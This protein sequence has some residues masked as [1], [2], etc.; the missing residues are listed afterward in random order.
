MGEE[1]SFYYDKELKKWVNKKAGVETPAAAAATPP[2]PKGPPS[3]AVSASNAAP[4]RKEIDTPPVPTLPPAAGNTATPPISITGPP[5]AAPAP[6][7][8]PYSSTPASRSESP[9]VV[10]SMGEQMGGP[11]SASAGGLGIA[12]SSTGAPSRPPTAMSNASSID[13]L[14]GAPQAR[15][16][17][18]IKKGKK[19]RGYVDVMAK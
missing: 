2:P 3:R 11:W 16:G 19:G 13:D 17:G 18:T 15:K 12:Q 6:G 5:A 7:Q 14:I 9:A 8:S 1:S 10:Q 4:V